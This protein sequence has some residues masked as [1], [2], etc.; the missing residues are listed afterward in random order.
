MYLYIPIHGNVKKKIFTS[1]PEHNKR[2]QLF[3]DN[4]LRGARLIVLSLRSI[5]RSVSGGWGVAHS[6][7]GFVDML[8]AS[9][10]SDTWKNIKILTQFKCFGIISLSSIRK[11]SIASLLYKKRFDCSG[12]LH[13]RETQHAKHICNNRYIIMMNSKIK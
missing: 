10:N 4:S 7:T 3:N 6:H 8:S 2:K 5:R 13:T 1:W 11:Q 9:S 12:Q